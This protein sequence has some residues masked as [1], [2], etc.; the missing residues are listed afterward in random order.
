MPPASA[1]PG[2]PRRSGDPT[3]DP[4]PASV[5]VDASAGDDGE[6]RWLDDDERRAW[7]ALLEVGTG[8]F[9]LLDRDLKALAELTL[10]DYEILHLLSEA[11]ER[12]LRVG[13]LVDRML[14]SRTRLS[15]RL[16]RLGHRG[17]VRR[18]RCPVDKRAINVILTDDGLALLER[19]APQHLRSVRHRLF[20]H[21]TR[22]DV[23]GLGRSLDKVV[24]G[25][26][27]QT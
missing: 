17:L 9:Q 18:E 19:I 11:P 7:L 12:S 26:R 6:I 24:R 20:D 15:Q 23:A 5:P 8:L 4:A 22:T 27:E 16:D 25:L 3:N 21:L 14:A 2:P 1:S 13:E 10:E